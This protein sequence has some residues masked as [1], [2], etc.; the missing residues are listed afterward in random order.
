MENLKRKMLSVYSAV[1]QCCYAQPHT[2]LDSKKCH[3]IMLKTHNLA[4][5]VKVTSNTSLIDQ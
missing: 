1:L 2:W 4:Y 3:F 5:G